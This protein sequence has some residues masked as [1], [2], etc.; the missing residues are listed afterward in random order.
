MNTDWVLGIFQ[1]GNEQDAQLALAAARKAFPDWSRIQW[2]ERVALLRK[3]ADL[4]DERLFEIGAAM[5]LE[6]GKNRMEALGDVAETADLIRYACDRDGAQQRLHRR[7]GPRPAGG[8]LL[9]PISPC[10]ARTGCG[11]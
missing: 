3:A 7:D 5:S 8:L 6:V 9:R 1:K 2:Q 4:I 10:C 11:W